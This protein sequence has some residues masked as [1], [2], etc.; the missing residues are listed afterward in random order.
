M[1][2]YRTVCV[3]CAIAALLVAGSVAAGDWTKLGKKGV[4]FGNDEKSA[5]ISVDGTEVEQIAFKI[6]GDWVMLTEA[7]FNFGDGSSQKI[8]D[9]EKVKPGMTS[10]GIAIDGGPKAVSSIDFSY[11]AASGS[12]QGRATITAVGQ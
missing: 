10:T 1:R 7:T 11:K 5:T 2:N 6:S 8:E 3:M 4:V 9:L 12:K